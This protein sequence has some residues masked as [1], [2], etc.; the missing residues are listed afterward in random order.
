MTLQPHPSEFPYIWG[1]FY[2]IFYQ[3]RR[4]PTFAR[5]STPL[6]PPPPSI[7]KNYT[8]KIV[9]ARLPVPTLGF[10][11]FYLE[12]FSE[13]VETFC[14]F[15]SKLSTKKLKPFVTKGVENSFIYFS[16]RYSTLLNLPPLRFHCVGG[17]WNRTQDSCDKDTGCQAP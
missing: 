13:N 10:S 6:S 5:Q 17:C 14:H 12:K 15:I 16:V 4:N 2:F 7:K 11:L 8:V 1:K 3:C 9:Q